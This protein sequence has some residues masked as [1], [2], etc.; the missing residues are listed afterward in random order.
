MKIFDD[1]VGEKTTKNDILSAWVNK[2]KIM[3]DDHVLCNLP[4]IKFQMHLDNEYESYLY[5]KNTAVKVNQEDIEPIAYKDLTWYVLD[6]QIID[7]DYVI[8][9]KQLA[10][11]NIPFRTF[12]SRISN[13]LN[14]RINAIESVIGYMLHRFQNPARA[15][16]IILYD[17]TINELNLIDGGVGKSLL[18]KALGYVRNLCE[19]SGKDFDSRNAFSFQRVATTT[20]IV[21]INDIK[22]NQ[23]FEIFYGRISDGFTINEKYKKEKFIAFEQSPK[24]IITS[25]YMLNA[26]SGNSSDRRRYEFEFS[27]YYGKHV[28]VY[29]DFGH[30]FFKDW[31]ISQWSDFTNYMVLCLQKYLNTGLIEAPYVNLVE[32]RLINEV[33]IELMEFLDEELLRAKKLHK[34]ELF[35]TFIRGGYISHKY[36]PT[37]KSFTTRIK[38]YFE[39]KG[40][41]YIET[42]SN[43]KIYFEVVEETSSV[44]YTTINDIKVNYYTVDTANKINRLAKKLEEHF[45][46][47][48]KEI[49]VI[50]LETIGLDPYKGEIVCMAL[51]FKERTG[52]NIIFPKHKSKIIDFIKPILPHLENESVVKVFHNAKFDLK[53]LQLYE[54]Q[55]S[56]IIK[57][58]LI[59]DYL[60]DPNRKKHGLKEI[61]KLHLHYSQ[62]SFEEL[63]KGKSILEIPPEELTLY[64][65]EDTDQTFQLY[66]FINNRLNSKP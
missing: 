13:G 36:H 63:T 58:T 17:E 49:L 4:N 50:D 2:A 61:S 52:Y 30:Y 16:A 38:K 27:S 41:N 51:T 5:F 10:D 7:R 22:Q 34:K 62:V 32:R 21:S 55:I 60:L 20:N 26:P 37:Q 48:P 40:I 66:H 1:N 19:I 23:N 45:N 59:M 64:A 43:T 9:Q 12:V 54:I 35:Q 65:C 57:D 39:Y 44:I 8:P 25:N 47:N 28:T 15:K 33:G 14:E 6:S 56:G 31:T 46:E 53:F 42:P 18:V 11:L 29:D 24:L 3:L